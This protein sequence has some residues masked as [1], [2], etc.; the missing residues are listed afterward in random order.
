MILNG[1]SRLLGGDK[2]VIVDGMVGN[3]ARLLMDEDVV[4]MKQVT[5]VSVVRGGGECSL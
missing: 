5:A 1:C 4:E 2:D 3:V